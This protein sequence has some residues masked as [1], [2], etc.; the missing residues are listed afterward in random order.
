ML[1]SGAEG[2]PVRRAAKNNGSRARFGTCKVALGKILRGKLMRMPGFGV[3]MRHRR[4]VR[5]AAPSWLEMLKSCHKKATIA[6]TGVGCRVVQ[7]P[8]G[9]NCLTY[10]PVT[11]L[12]VVSLGQ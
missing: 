10:D 12:S 5:G 2:P 1:Q 8:K 3:Q 4:K 6:P 9:T 7:G 11:W